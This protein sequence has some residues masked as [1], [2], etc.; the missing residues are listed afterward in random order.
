MRPHSGTS[1]SALGGDFEPGLVFEEVKGHSVRSSLTLA[2]AQGGGQLIRFA[3]ILLLARILTPAD[4]GLVAMVTSLI[5]VVQVLQDM[6][7]STVTLQRP[8]LTAVQASTLFWLRAGVG[9]GIALICMLAGPLVAS[10]YA[11]PRALGIVVALAA[12]FF[13]SGLGA[14]HRALLQRTLR[15]GDLARMNLFTVIAAAATAVALALEGARYWALVGYALAD[16][17]VGALLAWRYCRW[18]PSAPRFDR[19]TRDMLALGS[20]V[21]GFGVMAFLGRNFHN[22]LIGKVLG[23]EPVGL[24]GRA[25]G[26]V[27]VAQSYTN[28]ALGIVAIPSL[29]GFQGEPALFRRYYVKALK[30]TMLAAAPMACFVAVYAT[31]IVHFLLGDQWRPSAEL[32]RILVLCMLAQPIAHS[33]GWLF[34]SRGRTRDMMRWG[35]VGWTVLIAC[36]AIGLQFGLRGMAL[37][38]TAAIAALVVPNMIYAMRGT[39]VTL[40]DVFRS[41]WPATGAAV[42]AAGATFLAFRPDE[43]DH[44]L[45]QLALAAATFGAL[46]VTAL[47]RIFGQGAFILDLLAQ[48]RRRREPA[49]D[50]PT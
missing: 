24:Y 46:Y 12:G 47:A 13:I 34:L 28:S 33:S 42:M 15:F 44:S 21:V 6:G 22:V 36:T 26:L 20:Y 39:A 10:F 29:S 49:P 14:Q 8:Q 30:V 11:D 37:A 16:G 40:T 32:L 41:W 1:V 23:K 48:L 45:A 31:P 3:A 38:Y 43:S 25:F 9:A 7:L 35:F 27:S 4:F 18:R 19:S 5:G 17:V 2:F 50:A